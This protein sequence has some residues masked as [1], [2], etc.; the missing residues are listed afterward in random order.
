MPTKQ[1]RILTKLEGLSSLQLSHA[2]LIMI[3]FND[4][5]Q[6]RE[7]LC[8]GALDISQELLKQESMNLSAKIYDNDVGPNARS[9]SVWC[10]LSTVFNFKHVSLVICKSTQELMYC[11][12]FNKWLYLCVYIRMSMQ[13]LMIVRSR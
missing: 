6:F 5:A 7:V 3:S 12:G 9:H 4:R 10:K 13:N 1:L 8:H 2:N 11:P